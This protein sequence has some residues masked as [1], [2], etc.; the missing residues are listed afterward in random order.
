MIRGYCHAVLISFKPETDEASRETTELLLQNLGK[1]CGGE[2]AGILFWKVE[3]NL[4]QR[5]GVH[6]V[7]LGIF[8]NLSAYELFRVHPNHHSVGRA[9][10]LVADWKIGDIII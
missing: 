5:K 7:E 10:S 2:Q 3:K 4:D 9:L 8:A 6:L 1:N